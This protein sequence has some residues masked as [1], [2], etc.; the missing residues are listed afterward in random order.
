[1][2]WKQTIA[3]F[4]LAF[5]LSIGVAAAQDATEPPPGGVTQAEGATAVLEDAS[6]N[7]VGQVTFSQNG[8]GKVIILASITGMDASGFMGFHIHETGQCDASGDTPFASAGGHLNPAGANHPDH[9]GDLPSLLVSDDGT[10]QLMV[11][12]DRFTLADL[13][14]ADGSAVVIHSGADNFANIPE[15][16]GQADADTLKAG[17]SGTRVACGV[18]QQ[19][20]GMT[21]G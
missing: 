16:Y 9:A 20:D 10:G 2:H 11:V 4:G 14:D 13:F 15:R 18:I 6:G 19:D 1:M 17:D 8:D 21:A 5:A 3:G 12:T 7:N